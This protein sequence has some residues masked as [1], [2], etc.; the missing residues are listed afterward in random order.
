MCKYTDFQIRGLLGA[1]SGLP[2]LSISSYKFWRLSLFW[3]Q[4]TGDELP[5][6]EDED[7]FNQS[8]KKSI[9]PQ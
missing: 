5:P 3:Q 8:V 1:V 4:K 9:N 6:V 7:L 2:S